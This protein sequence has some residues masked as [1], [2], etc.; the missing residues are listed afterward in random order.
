MKAN[1]MSANSYAN[2]DDLLSLLTEETEA[3]DLGNG[4]TA[5][6]RSL[7]YPDVQS[8]A[9]QNR[10]NEE[11]MAMAAV[12]LG[13]KEPQLTPEQWAVAEKGKAGPL[14]GIG[15]RVMVISGM[16]DDKANQGEDSASS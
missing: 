10:G 5:L 9:R 3:Y 8:I 12:K 13:M 6:L 1:T 2:A 16:A 4:K 15:K 11:A 14:L 7:T